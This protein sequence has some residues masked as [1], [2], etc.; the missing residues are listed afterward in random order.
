MVVSPVKVV[1]M[2][3]CTDLLRIDQAFAHGIAEHGA[4]IDAAAIV[5]FDIA[6][7]VEMHQRQGSM[8]FGMGLEQA[9]R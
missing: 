8:L 9:D 5:D 7:G 3:I 1:R 2:P 4:V 6:V